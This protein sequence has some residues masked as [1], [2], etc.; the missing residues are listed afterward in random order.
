M[1]EVAGFRRAPLQIKA[2]KTRVD[3]ALTQRPK[4]EGAAPCAP[5]PKFRRKIHAY[6]T[7]S[8]RGSVP[9][10]KAEATGAA[11][12]A[13]G[14]APNP[15]AGADAPP[16]RLRRRRRG[17]LPAA[18]RTLRA[19]ITPCVKRRPFDRISGQNSGKAYTVER[20]RERERERERGRERESRST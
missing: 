8:E 3:P 20:G 12:N 18:R 19:G 17:R 1:P 14:A 13:E 15:G 11:P 7:G 2:L 4:V 6:A 5:T 10:P 9:L 16:R